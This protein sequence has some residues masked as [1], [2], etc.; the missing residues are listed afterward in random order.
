MQLPSPGM[1][2]AQ[3]AGVAV[4]LNGVAAIKLLNAIAVDKLLVTVTV[5]CIL[6]TASAICPKLSG[7]AA[8]FAGLR[9]NG[10]IV[11]VKT[12][13]TLQFAVIAAVV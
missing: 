11:G 2:L 10:S 6:S 13:A 3:L 9:V 5:C 8:L 7:L 12:A 1:T 4:K